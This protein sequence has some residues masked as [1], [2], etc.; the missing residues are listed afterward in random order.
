MRVITKCVSQ[1]Q[2]MR[3]NDL[4]CSM[5]ITPRY[6]RNLLQEVKQVNISFHNHHTCAADTTI[7]SLRGR[8]WTT[9]SKGDVEVSRSAQCLLAAL[10]LDNE[11]VETVPPSTVLGKLI[12]T[13]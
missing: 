9:P 2:S 10:S 11:A 5:G 13:H 8:T 3:Y 4:I 6:S 7:S 1:N 12:S